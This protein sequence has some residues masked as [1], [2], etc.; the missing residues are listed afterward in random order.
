M[1]IAPDIFCAAVLLTMVFS[2]VLSGA[3][4]VGC[5]EWPISDREV[6]MDVNF[7]Q[8]SNNPPSFSSV[9]DAM[10]FIMILH[11]TFNGPFTGSIAV[12]GVLDF[13]PRKK[14]PPALLRASGSEM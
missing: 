11:S 5:C 7:W 4:V 3:T 9:D 8:F 12:I 2:D 14:Y 1:S 13:G 10:T 6:G